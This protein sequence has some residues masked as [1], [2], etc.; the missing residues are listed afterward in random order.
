MLCYDSWASEL[1]LKPLCA[2]MKRK[3][4]HNFGL[5]NPRDYFRG[6]NALYF[7]MAA[8]KQVCS[9]R[10]FGPSQSDMILFLHKSRYV[11]ETTANVFTAICRTIASAGV[12]A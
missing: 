11:N 9:L 5:T 7:I 12:M 1:N 10:T 8:A 3:N 2:K 4:K 6:Q